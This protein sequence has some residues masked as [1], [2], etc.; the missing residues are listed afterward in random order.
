MHNIYLIYVKIADT[1]KISVLYYIGCH[2][3]NGFVSAGCTRF[4]KWAKDIHRN[5]LAQKGHPDQPSIFM[6]AILTLLHS[7]PP[8]LYSVLAIL[9]AIDLRCISTPLHFS[10]I[11]TE[12]INFCAFVTFCLLPWRMTPIQ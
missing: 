8:K 6:Q 5:T 12:E 1:V 10:A 7:E 9:S 4:S 11:F 3:W 2:P